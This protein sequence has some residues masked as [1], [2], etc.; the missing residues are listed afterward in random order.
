MDI[1]DTAN[2]ID[3]DIKKFMNHMLQIYD[4]MK[5]SLNQNKN[6][7]LNNIGNCKLLYPCNFCLSFPYL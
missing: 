4:L 3:N 2:K 6:H 5:Y 1:F 7:Y